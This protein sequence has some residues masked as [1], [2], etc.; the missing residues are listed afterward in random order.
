MHQNASKYAHKE[1][2]NN[3]SAKKKKWVAILL[4]R[5]MFLGPSSFFCFR[6]IKSLTELKDSLI[7]IFDII[8]IGYVNKVRKNIRGKSRRGNQNKERN[9]KSKMKTRP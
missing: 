2:S 9:V 1:H 6:K 8:T 3:F 7:R 5:D 4:N